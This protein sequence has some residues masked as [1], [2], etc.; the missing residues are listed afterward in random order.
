MTITKEKVN[1]RKK[2]I[3]KLRKQFDITRL[4]S[5]GI[6]YRTDGETVQWYYQGDLMVETRFSDTCWFWS[7]SKLIILARIFK[8]DPELYLWLD[9]NMVES[10][11]GNFELNN[12]FW[13]SYF[14]P[15]TSVE[16]H[17]QD[18]LPSPNWDTH[19]LS[20]E[21]AIPYEDLTNQHLAN[22]IRGPFSLTE[23]IKSEVVKRFGLDI[24]GDKFAKQYCCESGINLFKAHYGYE[25]RVCIPIKE[26][27][28]K[29]DFD[30]Q[31]RVLLAGAIDYY[32]ELF[33]Q[34]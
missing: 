19:W 30:P 11:Y 3:T 5:R 27:V 20:K 1:K 26:L 14:T 17:I 8:A 16:E 18:K 21:R 13:C 9:Q 22:I 25:G 2:A 15:S 4:N 32:D 7:T 31:I 33:N 29:L 12:P 23:G 24:I 34:Q 6:Y 10:R 28:D